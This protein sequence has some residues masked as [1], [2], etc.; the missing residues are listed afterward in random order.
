MEVCTFDD[1]PSLMNAIKCASSVSQAVVGGIASILVATHLG[2]LIVP[3][4]LLMTTFKLW[5]VYTNVKD[6]GN[7]LPLPPGTMGFPLVGETLEFLRKGSEFFR[8]RTKS[9][10]CIYKTH[11]L[12]QRTIRVS[13]AANV[14]KILKG[15][16][17]LVASQ[18]PPSA[19]FILGSGALAHSKGEKHAWRRMMIAK[20]F[21]PDAVATYIPAIQ[22]TIRDYIGQWCRSG[23]IHGYPEARSLTFTVAARMLLGFNV[24]DKQKHQMLILFEDMLATLFSMPVPIPGIGLYKGLKAR[25][26]IM[27]EIGQCIQKRQKPSEAPGD[28]ALSKILHAI[29][30]DGHDAL[31][32]VEMQDSALEMLFAGHLPTSSAACSVLG[33]IASNPTVYDKA[34]M[35][36]FRQ[37]LLDPNLNEELTP[38]DIKNLPYIDAIIK[39][40]LRVAP[41]VGAGY[42][43]ALKTFDLD[44]HQV[45][46]GWTIIYSIRETQHTSSSYSEAEKFNPDRWIEDTQLAHKSAA[47]KVDDSEYDFVPFGSGQRSCV[48]HRYVETFLKIFIIELVRN[49][50]WKLENGLPQVA[51]MPVPH[52]V[53]N[54]PLSFR[55][56]EMEQRR[57]AFTLPAK[58]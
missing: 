19:K 39:E 36:L 51:Y 1:F 2:P 5:S 57:R 43:K 52:P 7:R 45:P 18:W 26:R 22:E 35:E 8:E 29:A 42:R 3:S 15:E 38:S 47:S 37:G 14:A 48:A 32:T 49:S 12:G 16:G 41:P 25:R 30:E 50:N 40:V 28:D 6:P 17:E 33:L 11:I 58:P 27:Q 20:A 53:D 54:L 44:G 10:G 34:S 13:G 23:H 55:K 21:T 56:V 46:K 31:S 4:L 9:Y 24:H